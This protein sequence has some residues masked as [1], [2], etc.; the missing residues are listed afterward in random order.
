MLRGL[1]LKLR[2]LHETYYYLRAINKHQFDISIKIYYVY[3]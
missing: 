3:L 1:D 2:I